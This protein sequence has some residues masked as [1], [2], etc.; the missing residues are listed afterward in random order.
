ME[1]HPLRFGMASMAWFGNDVLPTIRDYRVESDREYPVKVGEK[2]K[3]DPWAGT[4]R[5]V[6]VAKASVAPGGFW[7]EFETGSP[8]DPAA[9]RRF[10]S[11]WS[12]DKEGI[13]N[14]DEVLMVTGPYGGAR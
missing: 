5:E 1:R 8:G 13:A 6:G 3:E 9:P 4:S 7:V 10:Y 14:L 12:V 11:V 2:N